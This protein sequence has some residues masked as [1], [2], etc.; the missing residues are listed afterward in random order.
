MIL[1]LLSSCTLGLYQLGYS[2]EDCMCFHFIKIVFVK[3]FFSLSPIMSNSCIKT[4]SNEDINCQNKLHAKQN[5]SQVK[6]Y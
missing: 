3:L 6:I 1:W 4:N 2:L 5:F